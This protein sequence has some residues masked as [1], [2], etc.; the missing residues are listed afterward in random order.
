MRTQEY[1][2]VCYR[3]EQHDEQV[4]LVN[5]KSGQ[6][7]WTFGCTSEG[8]TVQ[9]RLADGTLD[10]WSREECLEVSH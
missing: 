4:Q 5:L 9:V 6:I 7:G 2:K 1:S 10:S 3:T 8:E